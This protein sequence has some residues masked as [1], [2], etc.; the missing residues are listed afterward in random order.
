LPLSCQFTA[1]PT[2]SNPWYQVMILIT[3]LIIFILGLAI[4]SF[5]NV[6][7][8]RSVH[9]GSILVDNSKCPHCGHKLS[10]LDLVPLLSFFILKGKCRY[11]SKNISI[12]YPIVE[13]ATGLL[14]SFSFLHWSN[15]LLSAFSLV[16]ISEY[17]SL[18][19]LLFSVSIL[20]V[21]FVTDLKSG[22]LPNIIVLPAI[23]VVAGFNV[24]SVILGTQPFSNLFYGALS[25]FIA[26]F[27][28]F[29]IVFLSNE[30]AMGGGDVK[31]VFLIGLIVGWPSILVGLFA[32]FLTG[33]FV[34]VTLILIGKKKFGQTI[35]FGPF[36]TIGGFFALFW[37][38]EILSMYLKTLN[39]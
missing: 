28:F 6:V 2:L 8:Y 29:A 18:L 7:A 5:L 32:G 10:A 13:L 24:L 14:F 9:G 33:A 31:L 27:V 25:A 21:L 26:A 12:Q 36:L 30:K 11:C 37:G 16:S 15:N 19:F 23:I 39:T 22:L 38:Q 3:T 20:L 34:A 17:L 35:A 4:G 1:S